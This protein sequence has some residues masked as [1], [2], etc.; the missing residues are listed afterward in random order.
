MKVMNQLCTLAAGTA[1]IALVALTAVSPAQADGMAGKRVVYERPANWSG[2]YFGLHSGWAWADINSAFV[3][4]AGVPTGAS[5]SVEHDAQVV[6]GQI[7]IQHQFGNFV[8]G[9]EASLTSS[10]RDGFA[11]V[12]CPNVTR[13]CGK[14]FDDVFSVGPRLGWAMGKWMPYVTGGYAN[15]AI[16]HESFDTGPG[17]NVL[18]GRERFD[19]WYIGGGVDMALAHGWTVG[20]DYRHYEFEDELFLTHTPAGVL[21]ADRRNVDPSLDIVTLRVSWKLGR[22]EPKPLK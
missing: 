12:T 5:D 17:T 6:G 20:L 11:N 9:V 14:R 13:T 10:F 22:P 21:S 7:G 4:A 3:N 19:G 16:S 8:L 2:F 18:L 15:T 1:A